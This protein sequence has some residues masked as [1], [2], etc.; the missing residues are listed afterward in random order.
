M[1]SYPTEWVANRTD[2]RVDYSERYYAMAVD[3]PYL[4]IYNQD[5]QLSANHSD[6]TKKI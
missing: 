1:A 3:G 2:M 6:A 4:T 5:G